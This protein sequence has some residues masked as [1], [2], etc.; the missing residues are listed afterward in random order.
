ME[1]KKKIC[2]NCGL[3][4]GE[5]EEFLE[6]DIGEY[7]CNNCIFECDDCREIYPITMCISVDRYDRRICENCYDE[8]YFECERC[9]EVVHNDDGVYVNT[10]DRYICD[11]CVDEHYGYCDNCEALLSNDD[12]IYSESYDQYYCGSCWEDMDIYVFEYHS[13]YGRDD[14]SE[15]YR[16]RVGIELEKE[17]EDVKRSIDKDW[18]L[19]ET[20]W[21]M[22][23]DSSLDKISGFEAVSPMYP[24]KLGRLGEI[25]NQED[26]RSVAR[27]D[28]SSRC[29]GHITIS[30]KKRTPNEIID[31]IT[32]YLP[33]LYA[34]F[35]NRVYRSYCEAHHKEFYKQNRGHYAL[36]KR[37]NTKG[38]GVEFRIFDSPDDEKDILNRFRLLKFMLQH[39]APTVEKA[40][41]YLNDYEIL[42][43]VVKY[44]LDTRDISYKTFITNL[45]G[46]AKSIDELEIKAD[47]D[48]VEKTL[49]K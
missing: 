5:K 11:R 38:D 25:F 26:I 8:N 7:Y 41:E 37:G 49:S 4:I 17:D 28:F 6:W 39:K 12:L 47:E 30:D 2:E 21:V 45:I 44:H 9:G 1:N 27:A 46:Y 10:E 40:L 22:E 3:E 29:G 36:N 35:P 34:M 13:D 14:E 32:G 33:L 19:D 24:L 16:Y 18:L 15:D 43:K 42:R 23:S 20:G 48:K 31:D